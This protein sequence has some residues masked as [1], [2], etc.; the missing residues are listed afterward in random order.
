MLLSSDCPRE[1]ESARICKL[2]ATNTSC[3][4]S[5][6]GSPGMCRL[7]HHLQSIKNSKRS[8]GFS[9]DLFANIDFIL[10]L[11][12]E[13]SLERSSGKVWRFRNLLRIS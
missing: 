4:L 3:E 11:L 6:K 2:E 1:K 8:L 7:M 5:V 13:R 12:E 9:F 10:L